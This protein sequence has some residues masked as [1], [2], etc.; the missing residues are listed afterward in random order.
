MR[1]R[2]FGGGAQLAR[3]EP[4]ELKARNQLGLYRKFDVWRASQRVLHAP[5]GP[6]RACAAPA[7]GPGLRR[8]PQKARKAESL[9]AG[10]MPLVSRSEGRLLYSERGDG[11]SVEKS[12]AACHVASIYY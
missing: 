1:V 4:K 8:A 9:S 6:G 12:R 2:K 3:I 10:R 7:P 5:A 11:A